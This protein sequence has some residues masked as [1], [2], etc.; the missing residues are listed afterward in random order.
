MPG[1]NYADQGG[2]LMSENFCNIKKKVA[3]M[4]NLAL[5]MWQ[6]TFKVFMDHDLE[7]LAKVLEDENRLNDFEK[8]LTGE[9]IEAGQGLKKETEKKEVIIY[10]EV[11]EDLEL[12]GDYCK[13]ILE[14]VQIKI[15]EKLLFSDDA[16]KEYVELYNRS[17]A[18]FKEVVQA[19][20][21]DEP[22]RLKQVLKSQEHIDTLVDEYRR[23]HNERLINKLCS[24]FSCNMFLNM[25]DFT[26]AIYY[27]TKKI[28]RNLLKI[29]TKC[30]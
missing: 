5:S 3:D 25:L 1:K 10:V 16:V 13:D 27:H 19:L 2:P 8:M 12:I 30:A 14:R 7:L 24:P 15:E 17:E 11:V 22:G 18:A 9:L 4:A 20:E 28:A 29:K 26:A 6:R 23:R 21:I